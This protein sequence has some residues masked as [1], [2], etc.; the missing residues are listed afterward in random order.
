MVCHFII[1]TVA[2]LSKSFKKSPAERSFYETEYE[3]WAGL[4]QLSSL[5]VHELLGYFVL[6]ILS[7]ILFRLIIEAKMMLQQYM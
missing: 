3:I 4:G 6:S 7:I 1:V 5:R 2:K